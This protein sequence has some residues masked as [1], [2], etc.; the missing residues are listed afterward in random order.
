M[1]KLKSVAV[2]GD[3]MLDVRYHCDVLGISP[4]DDIAPKLRIQE[5]TYRP[6]GAGNVALNL[7]SLGFAESV[8]LFCA[9]GDD[10]DGEMIA[11]LIRA[12]GIYFHGVVCPNRRTT[13]K[14]R[15]LT[16]R[17]KHVCRLDQESTH[18]DPEINLELS[19]QLSAHGL[20]DVVIVSDYGKGVITSDL[21]GC[22]RF[23]AVCKQQCPVIVDPKGND[24]EK[25]GR[26]FAVT[27]NYQ[28]F[29]R[30]LKEDAASCADFA[31]NVGN[32]DKQWHLR[33][34]A[35]HVILTRSHL[36]CSVLSRNSNGTY[37]SSPG[38]TCI[39][40]CR[41]EV[42]DPTGCGDSF[43]AGFV[44]RLLFDDIKLPDMSD[45]LNLN[46]ELHKIFVSACSF[47]NAAGACAYSRQ[48]ARSVTDAEVVAELT[49]MEE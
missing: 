21:M 19:R 35:E 32:Q 10:R 13:T 36:G 28:E 20:F 15:L 42:G 34:S 49:R 46:S 29:V 8:R 43:L 16:H 2:I 18:E 12:A 1:S 11:D 6:G 26:V 4:E 27:P 25:Y 22:V 30:A 39:P 38:L 41:R 40:V 23:P 48:G 37:S 24:F 31:F 9:V 45:C 7:K 3:V 47:A 5:K 14:T 44:S 17:G 33:C